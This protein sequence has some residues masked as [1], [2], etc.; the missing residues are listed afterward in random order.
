[1]SG[2]ILLLGAEDVAA[3]LP[4][5]ALL[6]SLAAT[7][8]AAARGE[9]AA[10]PRSQIALEGDGGLLV[11]PG[12]RSGQPL[13]VKHVGMYEGNVARGLPHHPATICAFDEGTGVLRAVIDATALTALRTAGA[14]ALSISLAARRD[15]RVAAVIGAGP[16]AAAHL[17]LL[18]SVR[19]FEELR[20]AARTPA[21]AARLAARH[22][23]RAVAGIEAAVRGADVICLCTSATSPVVRRDWLADGA[24]VTSVGYAPPGG[25]LDPLLARTGRLLVE[26]RDAFAPPPAGCAELAGIDPSTAAE[27]G[28]VV[29]GTRPGR[30]R[31]D[32]F[33][34][35][36]SMGT[37]IE[38]VAAAAVVLE[39]A[40][41][42]GAGTR[43]AF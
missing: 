14:A 24:H 23:A 25:E 11:M 5:A 16:V 18:A 8:A 27:L 32:E 10:P 3:L 37:V 17:E 38:D 41:A 26:S 35:Y 39:R 22:G 4:P 19:E 13:V 28:E 1:M 6:D 40:E 21:G 30:E 29:L 9:V 36:K 15:A 42:L 31:D 34:V 33:T 43:V 2:G 7:F 12:H 20:V